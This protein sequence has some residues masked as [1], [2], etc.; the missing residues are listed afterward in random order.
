MRV[1]I[2]L[3]ICQWRGFA[4][5]C[6]QPLIHPLLPPSLQPSRREN[7][8]RVF[9]HANSA[10][11]TLPSGRV[12][13][14]LFFFRFF[15]FVSPDAPRRPLVKITAELG[16]KNI[17]GKLGKRWAARVVV[18]RVQRS[19]FLSLSPRLFLLLLLL[20]LFLSPSNSLGTML[21]HTHPLPLCNPL[22]SSVETASPLRPLSYHRPPSGPPRP[23]TRP[24]QKINVPCNP[25]IMHSHFVE[26]TNERTARKFTSYVSLCLPL[27]LSLSLPP[28]SLRFHV[29]LSCRLSLDFYLFFLV[30]P[31]RFCACAT[32]RP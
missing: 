7:S 11:P 5:A 20:F 12:R 25:C 16:G 13:A 28:S 8:C 15:R 9:L 22:A 6:I 4:G 1:A 2:Y 24:R 10:R 3:I 32:S 29:S 30:S 27:P 19:D 21:V 18:E 14:S 23:T 31:A 26:R 17:D